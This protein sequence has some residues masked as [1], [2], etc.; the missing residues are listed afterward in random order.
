MH[1]NKFWDQ[2][3]EDCKLFLKKLIFISF[4]GLITRDNKTKDLAMNLSQ[5]VKEPYRF[6]FP[7]GTLLLLCGILIWLPLIWTGDIYPVELHRY[8]MLNGF[9]GC[10]IGG[11]LMTA[12]P[13]FSQT[14]SAKNFE[15]IIYAF[16]TLLGV[17]VAHLSDTPYIFLISSLQPIFLLSFLLR[18]ITKRKMNPPYSFVF[19]FVGLFMWTISGILSCFMDPESFK[20]LH[21]EGA[22]AC[23]ILGVGSRLIPGILGH[24][25]IVAAQR[26]SY[27]RPV[28]II[29]TVPPQFALLVLTFLGSY[30]LGEEKGMPLRALVVA[31]IG[32]FYWKLWKA[33]KDKTALTWCIW[34]SS[35]MIA[36]S[37]VLKSF[38]SEGLIHVGHSFFINGIALLSFLIATRVL[39]SHGPQDKNL[40]NKKV[41]YVFT[42]LVLLAAG[43]RVSAFLM[44]D[45]YL[46]HL[47]YA[48]FVLT[49]AVVIWSYKYLRFIFV[50][51]GEGK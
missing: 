16:I 21:Y 10:F 51:P 22:I 50:V 47:A 30:F 8:L 42:G 34:F 28:S 33:P 36:L 12:V 6:F 17:A 29:K 13:K 2:Q 40:E 27:E 48:S 44:P 26:A 24:V 11:F 19:I 3:V 35:W 9:T 14:D 41:L 32:L 5:F 18:R 43:T 38:W 23:I 1:F 46:R 49:L 15:V 25:E 7:L 4:K 39:Q 37:F 31:I 20:Y 45:H